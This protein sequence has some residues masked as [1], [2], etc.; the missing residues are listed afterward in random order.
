MKK[1]C[2]KCMGSGGAV[3]TM[4]RFG[5]VFI[6]C[7]ECMGRGSWWPNNRRRIKRTGNGR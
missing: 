5:E 7:K 3:R 2:L 6:N 4:G 1:K